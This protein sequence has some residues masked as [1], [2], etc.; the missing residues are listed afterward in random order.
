MMQKYVQEQAA[1]LLRRLASQAHEAASLGSADAV[2][3]LRVAIR[4]L[5]QCLRVFGNFFPRK[6][7]KK[8]RGELR[9]VMD[10]AGAVRNC[11]I[12]IELLKKAKLPAE[13]VLAQ[14]RRRARKELAGALTSWSRRDFSQK[15]RE[16]LIG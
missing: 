1:T 7:V 3:D 5:N 4:R 2:H 6:D 11:D 14:E 15:W 12:A 8:I 13:P 9:D 10:V 16:R